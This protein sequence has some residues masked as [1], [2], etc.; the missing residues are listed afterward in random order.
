MAAC[1]EAAKSG[2]NRVLRLESLAISVAA[3]VLRPGKRKI[4]I[5][6]L[7]QGPRQVEGLGVAPLSRT[8]NLDP[9]GVAQA[10]QF[11]DL[12]KGLARRVV[13]GRAQQM[14]SRQKRCTS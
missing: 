13:E 2:K 14:I 10:E 4:E 6:A 8:L 3:A 7:R 1:T 5:V 9:P 12:V 11:G